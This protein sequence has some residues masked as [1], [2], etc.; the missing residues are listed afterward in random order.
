MRQ[1]PQSIDA[2]Q[3]LLGMMFMYEDTIIKAYEENLQ[4]TDF[5]LPANRKIYQV[6]LDLYDE[7]KPYDVTSV[8]T[9]LTDLDQLSVV[10]GAEYVLQLANMA[11]SSGNAQY[12]IEIVQ[13]KAVLR[14]LIETAQ[15]IIEEG[16]ENP[17]EVGEVLDEAESMVLAVTRDRKT[18]DFKPTRIV[19]DQ[20]IDKIA[21]LQK[22]GK[23]TGV[24]SGFPILDGYTNGF[25]KGDLI[26]LAA[27]PS[28]G[29][30]AFALNVALNAASKYNRTVALFSLEMPAEHLTARMLACCSGVKLKKINDGAGLTNDDWNRLRIGQKTLG[31]SKIYLDDSPQIKVS[32]MF[33]K[34]RKLKNEG[35][36]D[37]VIVDYLQLITPPSLRQNDNRQ[38]QVSEMSRGLKALARELECPVIALSQLSR[39]IEQRGKDTRPMLSD[40]RESGAI[41]QDA[42]IVM[43]LHDDKGGSKNS[44]SEAV[45]Q[46]NFNNAQRMLELI[47]AKHRNGATGSF[48]LA[49]NAEINNFMMVANIDEN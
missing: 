35:N 7:K 2:E 21:L 30:S 4:V 48:N 40:L 6:I 24:P 5:Y 22:E 32:D 29:K 36:L 49:F 39:L 45:P 23:M 44:D 15:Q 38:Q 37:L 12:Y 43:F 41:E 13:S 1:L 3:A 33:A 31:K 47:I 20:V 16:Y 8:I 10:G 17:H 11:F 26:I 28:V 46:E 42:D 18:S 9:R 25:Q 14:R 34:C 27:R 19:V